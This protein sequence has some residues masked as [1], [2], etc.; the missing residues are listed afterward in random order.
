MERRE[1]EIF[2][3]LAEELHFG[4]TAQRLFVS[5]ARVSQTI[6]TLERRF[7]VTLFERTSRHVALTSVGRQLRDDVRAGHEQVLRGVA[8]AVAAGCG[9]DGVLSVGLEAP[10]VADLLADFLDRFQR[11]HTGT[12]VRLLES[13]FPDPLQQLRSGQVDVLVTNAPV[14]EP[15]LVAGPVVLREP[16]VLAVSI[17]HRLALRDEV[18]L[19][20]L[21]G[22]TVL[23]A[24][25]RAW[26][27]WQDPP[28][29]WRTSTGDTV[30]RGK[31]VATFQ[32]LFAAVA[33]GEGVCPVAAH[34]TA[35]FARPTVVFVRFDAAA[36][37]I[38][39][40]LTWRRTNATQQVRTFA[41]TASHAVAT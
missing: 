23:R 24:G 22:E 14:E 25:R 31:P 6:A 18:S 17:G 13:G 40:C 1:I 30:H 19:D 4:R 20:D 3:A 11:C 29:Q 8:T 39:W 41:R 32:D 10:A 9:V 7:G 34:A 36:P 35:Y 12:E 28:A 16:A 21:G 15:D 26:P 27:Y 33:R 2:L 5:Q 37:P 38:E